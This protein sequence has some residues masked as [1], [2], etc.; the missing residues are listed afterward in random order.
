MEEKRDIRERSRFIPH[1]HSDTRSHQVV[2]QF[3]RDEIA[4]ARTSANF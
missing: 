2:Q 3:V 4:L 1:H